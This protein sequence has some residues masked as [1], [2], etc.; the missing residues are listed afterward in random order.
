MRKPYKVGDWLW[1]KETYRF[2][3]GDGN[4]NDFGIS[5]LADNCIVW[6]I[7]GEATMN[8]PIDTKTRPSLFMSR[9]LSRILLEV[10]GVKECRLQ[11]ITAEEAI[12]EGITSFTLPGKGDKIFYQDYDATSAG[13][14]PWEKAIDSFSSLWDL[15][16]GKKKG[17]SWNDNPEVFMYQF[18]DLSLEHK[19]T[20]DM[21]LHNYYNC[22]PILFKGEMVRAILDRT[23]KQTTRI[24]K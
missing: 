11:K 15:I 12:N 19:T 13:W 9:K 18:K 14:C 4:P 24:K 20:Q 6:Y 17:C 10:T 1:V 2:L 8:Y 22:H 23:K 7:D 3:Q 21:I 16:N 5:Y